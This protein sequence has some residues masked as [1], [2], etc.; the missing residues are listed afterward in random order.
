MPLTS[1]ETLKSF[2][3]DKNYIT[4]I[5][6]A[7]GYESARR[8]AEDIVFQK[9]QIAIPNKTDDAIPTLQFCAHAITIYI[10]SFQQPLKDDAAIKKIKDLH[11]TAMNYLNNIQ[12]GEFPLYDNNGIRISPLNSPASTFYCS[13][14]EDREERV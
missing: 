4:N 13:E 14:Q 7:P 5:D 9:T 12:S 1:K 8:Q 2:L 3:S 10:M 11:D 6:D